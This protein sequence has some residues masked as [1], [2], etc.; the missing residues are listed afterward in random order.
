MGAVK[1]PDAWEKAYRAVWRREEKF[2]RRYEESKQNIL[3]Q[4]IGELAP[5]KLLET[6]H[7]AFAKAFDLVFEKGDELIARAGRLEERR[8][9][10]R[11]N[12]YAAAL[13]EDRKTLRAFS[14]E[15]ARA[16]RGNVLLSGAAG[17]GMGLFGVALPDIPLFTAMLLK[18]LYETA[19]SFGFD[20][21]GPTEQ[22]YVLCL[23]ET[24]LSDGEELRRK[25][26]ELDAFTQTGA[27]PEGADFQTQA[28]AAARRLSEALLYGKALQNIP[29]AGIVGGA[30]DAV[31]MDRVR[32]YA[33][34][35]YEKR[36]LLRRRLERT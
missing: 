5:E 18:N 27:W 13:R 8:Q 34:I 29:V 19:E 17:M 6:L 32:R 1:R 36:F 9:T 3:E 33:A 22:I 20:H 15:A 4:K 25:N 7:A 2:L 16:G 30:G 23:L 31:I 21:A 24:S 26:R 28:G 14:R 10:F 12:E 11:V 35:K